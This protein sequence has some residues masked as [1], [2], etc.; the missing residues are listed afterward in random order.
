M[1]DLIL[2]AFCEV[3]SQAHIAEHG[4]LAVDS[5]WHVARGERPTCGDEAPQQE[6]RREE[7]AGDRQGDN[8]SGGKSRYCRKHWFC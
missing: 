2:G 6:P 7:S 5:S 4:G 1:I 3:R 8:D